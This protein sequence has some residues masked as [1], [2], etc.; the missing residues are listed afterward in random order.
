[1]NDNQPSQAELHDL[2]DALKLDIAT[3]EKRITHY[4]DDLR[5]PV[6]WLAS[7]AAQ[8]CGR[9]IDLLAQRAA[10]LNF[11]MD[12][13]TWS[14]ILRG[15]WN[16]RVVG[17]QQGTHYVPLETPIVKLTRLQAAINALR[18]DQQLK[19]KAGKVP[20]VK[21]GRA[22]S[23]WDFVDSLRAPDRVNKFGIIVGRTGTE[24]S[25]SLIEYC[26]LNNHLACVHLEAPARP[27][28]AQFVADLA[29]KYNGSRQSNWGRMINKIIESV[30]SKR[31]IVVENVQRLYVE[32]AE[33]NQPVFNFLQKLQDDTGCA[34]VLTITPVFAETLT[35]K[36]ANG[37]FEQFIG[38]A[39]GTGEFLRLPDFATEEDV[40]LIAKS[41]GLQRA[42]NC[43]DY[44]V[45]ISREP[46]L[47]RILFGALQKAKVMAEAEKSKLTI[48]H[49]RIARGED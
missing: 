24:K 39:G 19:E 46:G 11:D 35:R 31:T 4:P 34:I 21:T 6:L 17:G 25:A 45:S 27:S 29:A 18:R 9:D 38:R 12:K 37:Y 32:K 7:Y 48:E 23:I 43:L 47:I 10:D 40:L 15:R 44:L 2:H 30:N 13:T 1:M 28:Y 14:K 8:E 20:F 26:R 49:L 22:A 5:E 33:A 3:I 41:F 36:L 16:R 42:E